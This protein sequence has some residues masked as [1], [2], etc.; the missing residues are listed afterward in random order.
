VEEEISGC[1]T[2]TVKLAQ[3]IILEAKPSSNMCLVQVFFLILC[4][5][6]ARVQRNSKGETKRSKTAARDFFLFELHVEHDPLPRSV[7]SFSDEF[8]LFLAFVPSFSLWFT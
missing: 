4:F 2:G 6:E 8:V 7:Q 3:N 1:T 5:V